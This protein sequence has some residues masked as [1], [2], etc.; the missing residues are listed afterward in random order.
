[1]QSLH[2]ELDIVEKEKEDKERSLSEAYEVLRKMR[3][4]ANN[5]KAELVLAKENADSR[6]EIIEKLKS[7]INLKVM[8]IGE[9]ESRIKDSGAEQRRLMAQVEQLEAQNKQIV[10]ELSMK[11]AKNESLNTQLQ[12]CKGEIKSLKDE[13]K[14]MEERGL[15]AERSVS[16]A[17][18]R[19]MVADSQIKNLKQE[20]QELH[21]QLNKNLVKL[22]AANT[23]LDNTRPELAILRQVRNQY[24]ELK[25]QHEEFGGNVRE[26]FNRI[27]E[28]MEYISEKH[29]GELEPLVETNVSL[30]GTDL[31]NLELPEMNWSS[32]EGAS[33]KVVEWLSA[34]KYFVD[35]V[36]REFEVVSLNFLGVKAELAKA[37][38]SSDELEGLM[39]IKL[40]DISLYKEKE[41]N[42]TE[43]NR[44]L[45]N[46]IFD[47]QREYEKLLIEYCRM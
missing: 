15:A 34:Y 8:E 3:T 16:D 24:K 32:L 11:D 40:N 47:L 1:M 43:E 9:C 10:T 18:A 30:F 13:R 36:A 33:K 26:T 35:L 20:N 19:Q 5:L 21:T 46:K 12:N 44:R 42:L 45:Q 4:E 31:C 22:E 37:K 17:K 38:T 23:E 27:A 2:K 14:E 25:E 41:R 6:A 29:K 7:E 39:Q 28:I